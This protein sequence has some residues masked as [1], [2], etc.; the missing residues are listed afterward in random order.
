MLS[1]V[2]FRATGA[3]VEVEVPLSHATMRVLVD[4]VYVL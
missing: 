1:G 4:C 2:A 3:G